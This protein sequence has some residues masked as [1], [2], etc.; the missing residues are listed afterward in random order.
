[1]AKRIDKMK[2]KGFKRIRPDL[3]GMPDHGADD[4]V[5]FRFD[6]EATEIVTRLF[7]GEHPEHARQ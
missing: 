3:R 5:P 1:M 6:H 4:V 7:E 2:T